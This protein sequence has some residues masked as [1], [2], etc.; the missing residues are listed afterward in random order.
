MRV[1]FSLGVSAAGFTGAGLLRKL[2]SLAWVLEFR[3]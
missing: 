1:Y 3:V 2:V